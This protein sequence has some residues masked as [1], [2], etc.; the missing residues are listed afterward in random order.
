MTTL[1]SVRGV[2]DGWAKWA[3]TDPGFFRLVRRGQW[4][5]AALLLAHPALGSFLRPCSYQ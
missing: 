5:R 2:N 1:V 3:I 4:Q